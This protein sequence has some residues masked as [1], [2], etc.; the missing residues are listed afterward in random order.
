[1]IFSGI[2]VLICISLFFGSVLYGYGQQVLDP[3]K[4]KESHDVQGKAYV[5]KDAQA[6]VRGIRLKLLLSISYITLQ[7]MWS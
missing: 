2:V 6:H 3:A 4:S 1:M 5:N 7:Q